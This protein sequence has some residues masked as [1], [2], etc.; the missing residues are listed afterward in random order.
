V[1]DLTPITGLAG[2]ESLVFLGR[3]TLVVKTWSTRPDGSTEETC[4]S[5]VGS[6]SSIDEVQRT[7]SAAGSVV[8]EVSV[9][10]RDRA[11]P[12]RVQLAGEDGRPVAVEIGYRVHPVLY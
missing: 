11:Q 3:L 1:S 10:M 5:H 12:A 7:T 2:F 6:V 8:T 9:W 4:T